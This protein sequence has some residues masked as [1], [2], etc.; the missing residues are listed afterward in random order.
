PSP[1]Y[2]EFEMDSYVEARTLAETLGVTL[3]QLQFDNPALRPVVW[4]G[5]KRIPKGYVVKV[6]RKSLNAPLATLMASIPASERFPIQTPDVEYFVQSGD[7][8]SAIARR[9]RTSVAQLVALNQLAD[10]NTLSIGQRLILPQDGA[11]ATGQSSAQIA[12]AAPASSAPRA[13]G[14]AGSRPDAYAVRRGDTLSTIARRYGVSEAALLRVND[15]DDPHR[16]FPGQ[17]LRFPTDDSPVVQV[18]AA[19][20]APSAIV[21]APPTPEYTPVVA[22]AEVDNVA[23]VF[24]PSAPAVAGSGTTVQD[25]SADPSDYSVSADGSIEIQASETLG[26][27]ADWVGM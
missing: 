22:G 4:E 19:A 12:A 17:M 13:S 24:D 6:Q 7:S 18:V 11:A 14:G 2:E 25:L 15:L 1:E 21:E 26:H 20:P 23:V 3:E 16:I 27:Y 5:D 8:L 9:F 10:R